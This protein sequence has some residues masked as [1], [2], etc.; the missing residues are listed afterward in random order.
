M[1]KILVLGAGLVSRPLVRY[2]LN[3]PDFHVTVASRT[4]SKAEALIA[5]HPRGA[6]LQLLANETAKLEKL[7]SEH[8]LAISLLPAPLHPVVA[9]MCVSHR[10]HMVTTSYVSPKMRALDGAARAAGVMLLNEVGVDPGID[11]M[12]A[13]RIIH[14]VAKRGGQVVSFKS[15]CGGLP[16]PEANDN[17]WGYK[18]SWSP[19]GVCTAGKNAARY[20]E[21]GKLVEIPGPELFTHHHP[22]P[23][24][25]IGELEGYP[26]RDSLIYVEI[27]GLAGIETM[28]RGTLRYPGWCACLKKVV[29]LGLLDETPVTYP[30]GMTFA[31]W[32]A[33]FIKS[34]S[35]K[36]LRAQVAQHLKLDVKSNVLD[37]FEWLGLF[38]NHPLPIT[39]QQTTA[40]DVLAARLDAKMPYKKGERDMIVLIHRF[41]AR[42]PDG[43]E[44]RIS[45]TLID[46]GQPD[47]DSSMART[48]SLPAAVGSKLIL[49]G[50]IRTTGVHV[51]VTPEIYNPILDE[52]AT[53][54]ICCGEKTER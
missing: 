34:K 44:E 8:D 13:M 49:T 50:Q 21:N 45:S 2:L 24:A 29:D 12:S 14:D 6:A 3:P 10:K 1:K 26:N 20:R 27:Y 41:V 42:F 37:R 53:M 32:I 33:G 17:P 43:K 7:V 15:Y 23:V 40:L 35:T 25:G 18:F 54:D 22:V 19:R 38:S 46:Y 16:A 28:F 52:L 9:E 36:D 51:P 48:V 11:H 39:G 4:V 31:E 30:A 5:G 47:G